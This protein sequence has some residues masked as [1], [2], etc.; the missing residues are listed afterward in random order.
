MKLKLWERMTLNFLISMN[1]PIL[2]SS[3]LDLGG[4]LSGVIMPVAK[5]SVEA[6]PRRRSELLSFVK[7]KESFWVS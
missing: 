2:P 3:A 5:F 1:A 4:P 6:D 7:L